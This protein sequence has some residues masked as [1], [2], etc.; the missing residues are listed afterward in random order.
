VGNGADDPTC[1]FDKSSYVEDPRPG[2]CPCGSSRSN[3]GGEL[4]VKYTQSVSY[5]SGSPVAIDSQHALL[6]AGS[7]NRT[8]SL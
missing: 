5:Y 4:S 1:S 3:P 8:L 6:R 2:P 7:T